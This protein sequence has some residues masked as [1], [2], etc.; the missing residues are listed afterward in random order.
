MSTL[1][2]SNATGKESVYFALNSRSNFAS[3]NI[4]T[5]YELAEEIKI[6]S[7]CTISAANQ[8]SSKQKSAKVQ[9]Q[10]EQAARSV[11]VIKS[12]R[13][14]VTPIIDKNEFQ[15]QMNQSKV[16]GKEVCF[17]LLMLVSFLKKY[18]P[19]YRVRSL[20][21]GIGSASAILWSTAFRMLID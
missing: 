10:P 5:I 20:L 12:L 11:D 6:S 2:S 3:L 8:Y 1:T 15:R 17:L 9:V 7:L 19:D 21:S 14:S 4:V 18:A 13:E 16:T